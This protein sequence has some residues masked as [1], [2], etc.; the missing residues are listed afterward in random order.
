MPMD[1]ND[2]KQI[3]KNYRFLQSLKYA[4]NGGKIAFIEERNF[5]YHCVLG[6]FAV[7]VSIY[8]KI[9]LGEW[10]WITFA[11]FQVLMMEMLNTIAENLVDMYTLRNYHPLGKKVKDMGATVVLLSSIF[12]MVVAAYIFIPK[13]WPIIQKIIS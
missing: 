4:I 10:L 1:Y 2:K 13:V 7:I 11:I 8:F 3:D 5:R 12:A 9:S 6:I